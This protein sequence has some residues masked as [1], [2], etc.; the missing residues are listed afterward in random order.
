MK[1]EEKYERTFD[2]VRDAIVT[3]AIVMRMPALKVS[4]LELAMARIPEIKV[5]FR[6]T[7]ADHLYIVEE[8]PTNLTER[9]ERQNAE[10]EAS[11]KEGTEER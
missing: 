1:D 6:I 4:Q 9:E 8:K 3:Y 7:S 2:N 11:T 10:R 5:V